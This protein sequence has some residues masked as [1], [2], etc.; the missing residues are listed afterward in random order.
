M[1]YTDLPLDHPAARDEPPVEPDGF[2]VFWSE[3][4]RT[5]REA[6]RAPEV[7]PVPDSP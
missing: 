2:D 6:G 1:P 7:R 3:T 4:L 5:A